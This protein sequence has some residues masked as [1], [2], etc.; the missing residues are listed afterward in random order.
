[1][2]GYYLASQRAV[3]ASDPLLLEDCSVLELKDHWVW[4]CWLFDDGDDFHIFFLRASRALQDPDRR[5]FRASVGHAKSKDLTNWELLPDA[6]FASDSPAWD[7]VATWTGSVVKNEVDGLYY[8]FYTGV[9]RPNGGTVQQVGYATSKDLIEWEKNSSNPV[10]S[11]DSEL[12]DTQENG[13]PD[14]NFRDPWVFY[15]DEDKK[16]HMYVT[17]DLKGG[18]IKTRATVAHATS[19]DLKSWSSEQPLHGES[20]FGQVEVVQVEEIDGRWV[21]VFCVGEQHLNI[22]KP[23]F[24]SGTYSVPMDTQFGPIHFDSADIIDANGIYAGRIIKDRSGQW[25]LLG[26]ENGQIKSEFKGRICNP[27]PL[28]MTEAGTLKVKASS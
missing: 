17:A 2:K 16:W 25:V 19:T 27:I 3:L 9:T 21:M 1:M 14:T 24:K 11:A 10:M 5:H 18:G 4:D 13:S 15:S 7:E 26:F 22:I 20:G 23:G 12:Y 28:E 8:T 6:L